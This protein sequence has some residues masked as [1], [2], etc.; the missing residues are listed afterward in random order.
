MAEDTPT[1]PAPATSSTVETT[2]MEYATKIANEAK[3]KIEKEVPA[4]ASTVKKEFNHNQFTIYFVILASVLVPYIAY[5][6]GLHT[7]ISSGVIEILTGTALLLGVGMT[8]QRVL[9]GTS[10]RVTKFVFSN[11]IATAIYVGLIWV[12]LAIVIATK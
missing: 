11:P 5:M 8:L 6:M 4:M 12:S 7:V 2:I 1:N 9:G 3:M 10:F